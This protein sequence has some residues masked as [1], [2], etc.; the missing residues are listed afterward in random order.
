MHILVK[1]FIAVIIVF[2]VKKSKYFEIIYNKKKKIVWQK[3]KIWKGS[4]TDILRELTPNATST[5]KH[6]CRQVKYL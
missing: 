2:C 3:N 5:I 1:K 4:I 6:F